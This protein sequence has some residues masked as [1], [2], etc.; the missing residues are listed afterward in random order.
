[1]EGSLLKEN[2][3]GKIKVAG[4]KGDR[5]V[6]FETYDIDGKNRWQFVVSEKDLKR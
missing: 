1:V 5:K 6:T 2:N 4:G 3:F